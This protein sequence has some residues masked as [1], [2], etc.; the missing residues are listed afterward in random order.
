MPVP[1]DDIGRQFERGVVILSFDVEQ[2][3]GYLDLLDETQFREQHPN[4]LESHTKMLECLA[5]A[6]MRA[7]W[8]VVGALG[9]H[10]SEG[11]RDQRMAGLPYSWTTRIR[12]GNELTAPLW[13]RHSFLRRLRAL[14][15]QQEIGLHGGLTHFIWTDPLAS[16]E[17]LEWELAE[18]VRALEDAG[19]LPVSFSFGREQEAFHSLLP[20][21]GIMC[22]RGRTVAPSFR[23]GPN[24][25]G[26]AARL[27][28][29]MRRATPRLVL[30]IE[31]VPGLWSI[32]S[33]LFLYSIHASRTRFTGI[34]SRVDRFS[35]GIEAAARHRRI[36]HFCLHPEN[37]TQSPQG[38]AMFEQLL[39]R[40]AASRRRGDIEI[41]TMR[42]VAVRMECANA[43]D[44]GR[45]IPV[46]NPRPETVHTPNRF[47]TFDSTAKWRP[48]F[49]RR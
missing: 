39:E 9:L 38:F 13:Y 26:K 6:D 14:R 46:C 30:P 29:E 27:F 43:R 16:R 37:L 21:H 33:S 4:A 12:A 1:F 3:W 8:F 48:P 34:Q 49:C 22:Y 47:A 42:D 41:L 24:I 15:P 17:V 7:T 45:H 28:D 19:V 2:I 25:C 20:A 32:P 44:F 23:L 36:F 11:D 31:T 35:R 40:L 18:G 5:A 10:G